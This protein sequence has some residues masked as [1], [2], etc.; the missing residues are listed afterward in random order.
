MRKAA[1]L[2][3]HMD[4]AARCCVSITPSLARRSMFGVLW[5]HRE[6][7]TAGSRVTAHSTAADSDFCKMAA[8]AAGDSVYLMELFP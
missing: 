4:A 5:G 6:V 2:G 7:A 1:R 3:V 8:T